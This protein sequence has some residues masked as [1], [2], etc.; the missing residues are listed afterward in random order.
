MK[1]TTMAV[2]GFGNAGQFASQFVENQGAKLIA[3][4][5]SRGGIYNKD[6]IDVAELRRHKEKTGSVVEFP[7][8]RSIS[9]E[10]SARNRMHRTNTCCT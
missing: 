8:T 7:G 3:A 6:G 1:D 9:N 4:S 10:E 2:E 5:D